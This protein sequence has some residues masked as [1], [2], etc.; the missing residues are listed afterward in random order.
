MS[1]FRVLAGYFVEL[2]ASD[3]L[4]PCMCKVH[5]TFRISPTRPTL[6]RLCSYKLYVYTYICIE[7]SKYIVAAGARLTRNY[8]AR[9][10]RGSSR[11]ILA[12]GC[13]VIYPIPYLYSSFSSPL[14]LFP[15]RSLW[16]ESSSSSSS[17]VAS[18]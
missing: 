6:S 18:L 15:R 14:V 4:G 11:V 12:L 9:R 7:R 1:S 10:T 16:L 2:E 8:S 5:S 17:L 13:R 3:S